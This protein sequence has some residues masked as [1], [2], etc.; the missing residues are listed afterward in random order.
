MMSSIRQISDNSRFPQ[1]HYWVEL[2]KNQ[3]ESSKEG[4]NTNRTANIKLGTTVKQCITI[5]VQNL[6]QCKQ[7]TGPLEISPLLLVGM[8]LAF[9][10]NYPNDQTP[11]YQEFWGVTIYFHIIAIIQSFGFLL[12]NWFRPSL[13]TTLQNRYSRSLQDADNDDSMTLFQYQVEKT[14]QVI[15]NTLKDD[16]IVL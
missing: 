10:S 5:S 4:T 13:L 14:D 2:Y 12:P 1:P 8:N 11:L 7:I 15:I 9:Y 3:T 6:T 16:V